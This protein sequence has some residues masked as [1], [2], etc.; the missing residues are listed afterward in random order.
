[1]ARALGGTTSAAK[2]AII[3]DTH[4]LASALLTVCE[5]EYLEPARPARHIGRQLVPVDTFR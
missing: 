4:F 5:I 2:I 1:M 3:T